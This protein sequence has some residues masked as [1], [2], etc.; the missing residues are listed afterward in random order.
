MP[1]VGIH[2]F[3][4]TT[5]TDNRI[6]LATTRANFSPFIDKAIKAVKP[7]E[8]LLVGGA[9]YKVLLLLEGINISFVF[10]NP[11][12]KKENTGKRV[13]PTEFAFFLLL[14]F[15]LKYTGK[16]DVYLSTVPGTKKWDTCAP[17][18]LLKL[19]GGLMTDK[20]GKKIVYSPKE[21]HSNRGGCVCTREAK[22]H[23]RIIDAIKDLD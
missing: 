14:F 13:C 12:N 3:E 17:E 15:I 20:F 19:I 10:P 7:D 2:G 11:Q 22:N 1:G 16:A 18:A 9:G 8:V 6:I 4:P 23:T 5:R 21:D